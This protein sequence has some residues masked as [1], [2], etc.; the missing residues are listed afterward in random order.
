MK[1]VFL[2]LAIV[3]LAAFFPVFSAEACWAGVSTEELVEQSD[4]IVIGDIKGI[5][6]ME[7][8]GGMWETR[9]EVEVQYFLKGDADSSLLIVATPGAKNKQPLVSTHYHLNEWG[10]TVLLFLA[11]RKVYSEPLSPQ[12][13]V[14]LSPI[15]PPSHGAVALNPNDPPP[16]NQL[17]GEYL[18]KKYNIIDEKTPGEDKKELE[19]YIAGLPRVVAATSKIDNEGLKDENQTKQ[20]SSI[21]IIG[22]A[23]GPTSIYVTGSPLKAMIIPVIIFAAIIFAG[24]FALCYIIKARRSK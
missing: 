16:Q 5:S 23:D 13:V 19:N 18:M 21:G 11:K 8:A 10:D 2:L 20:S 9:W 22:G 3:L 14:A 24:G 12:G 7:K 15:D 6:G 1:A 4:L 17:S